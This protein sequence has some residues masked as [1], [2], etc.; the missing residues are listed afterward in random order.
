MVSPAAGTSLSGK[1]TAESR[2]Q[3]RLLT[4]EGR[5]D[6]AIALARQILAREE[7]QHVADSSDLV[8]S[9]TQLARLHSRAGQYDLA[10]PLLL[11]TLE[12]ARKKHGR[13]SPQSATA[14]FNLAWF[15]ANLAAYREARPL[16]EEALN[17]R[18]EHYGNNHPLVAECLNSLAV[19]NENTGQY[20]T[21]EELYQKS[22]FI[23][24]QTL[25]SEHPSAATTLNNL[26]TLYWTLGR[27]DEAEQGFSQALRIRQKQLGREHPDTATTLNNLAMLYRSM[28]DYARAK[29]LFERVLRIRKKV[30]GITHVYTITSIGQLGQLLAEQGEAAKAKPLLLEALTRRQQT[31]GNKHPDT[32]RNLDLLAQLYDQL[33]LPE[34]AA[35]LLME[36]LASRRQTLGERHAETAA[37]LSH[38]ARHLHR[39]GELTQSKDAY[40]QALS[41]QTEILGAAHPD[42]L[43][44][45]KGLAYVEH[46][47]EDSAQAA[48]RVHD[49][50]ADEETR[51]N[52]LFFFAS[53]SQRLEMQRTLDLCS[54]AINL[55]GIDD[56]A[57]T[58]L[59]LKG[60]ALDSALEDQRQLRLANNPACA[61][62]LARLRLLS[63]QIHQ[64]EQ[65]PANPPA[66][67]EDLIE[68]QNRV[69]SQLTRLTSSHVRQTLTITASQVRQAIP[70]GGVLLEYIRYQFHQGRGI[71]VPHYG[72]LVLSRKA[73]IQWIPLGPAEKIDALV[74]RYQRYVRRSVRSSSLSQIL[75][76]LHQQIIQP[77]TAV[78]TNNPRTLLISPDTAL[79]FISFP[80]LLNGDGHFL[81]E[82]YLVNHLTSGRDLLQAIPQEAGLREIIVLAAPEFGPVHSPS[83]SPIEC[84]PLP[85]SRREAEYL[86]SAACDWHAAPKVFLGR[87]ATSQTL[88]SVRSPW[89]LHLAVHGFHLRDKDFPSQQPVFFAHPMRRNVLALNGAQATLDAMAKGRPAPENS[90]LF[91]AE[92]A[93]LLDLEGT[94]L[95]ALSACDTGAG[96]VRD[97]EG[98]LGL[99]RGF[100]RA[101]ARNVLVTLWPV[102]DLQTARFMRDFY[103]EAVR[104]GNASTALALTQRK[105]LAAF[106]EQKGLAA[107]VRLAGPFLLT[108]TGR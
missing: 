74:E 4:K 80:T 39:C 47:M 69:E 95:A 84:Q 106:R 7:E 64:A 96:E 57:D 63:R 87:Q 88:A 108:G 10:K 65:T 25:G 76:Q 42:T 50:L 82:Q 77:V 97:G 98:V 2:L 51:L 37:S 90:G 75:S 20:Q 61:N 27:Y 107:A 53:E 16:F 62:L 86:A 1:S 92:D 26:S 43:K 56:I 35:P 29:P 30:L 52:Q 85:A 15:H 19:L 31:L 18:R 104:S 21:S 79:N 34:K 6:E 67:Y 70:A 11:R 24:R 23:Q 103:T 94:W 5:N 22:L 28:G 71:F 13:E 68:E 14:L 48:I 49:L 45:R 46:A 54:L 66:N 55:G 3:I 83:P 91:T 105:W 81:G 60:L 58:I 12:I 44:T 100:R 33:N 78:L 99:R 102:A 32:A 72:A 8:E 9:L 36:A 17:I 89:I 41:I 40:L 59:R 73:D 38:L 101:G 93:A